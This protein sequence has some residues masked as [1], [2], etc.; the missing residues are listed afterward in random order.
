MDLSPIGHVPCG[1][2][3]NELWLPRASRRLALALSYTHRPPLLEHS[4]H[5]RNIP[6][7]PLTEIMKVAMLSLWRLIT[8][9]YLAAEHLHDS[10]H[11]SPWPTVFFHEHLLTFAHTDLSFPVP[12]LPLLRLEL[13]PPRLGFVGCRPCISRLQVTLGQMNVSFLPD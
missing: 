8:D 9:H 10:G 2:V 7:G 4:L 5:L 6:Y 1:R 11:S 13:W 12:P 3:E